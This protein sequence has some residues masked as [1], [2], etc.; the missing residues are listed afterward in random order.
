[1]CYLLSWLSASSLPALRSTPLHSA[2]LQRS[3]R[4]GLALKAIRLQETFIPLFK[5]GRLTAK[6]LRDANIAW[7]DVFQEI[8]IK[9]GEGGG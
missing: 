4:G 6:D 9:V 1:M 8:P 2:P 5:E 3:S 7:K